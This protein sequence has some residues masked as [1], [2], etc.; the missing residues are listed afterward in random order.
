M[1]RT[2]VIADRSAFWRRWLRLALPQH[3]GLEVLVFDGVPAVLDAVRQH[4]VDLLIVELRLG[5]PDLCDG[6]AWVSALRYAVGPA[7]SRIVATISGL[8]RTGGSLARLAGADLAYCKGQDHVQLRQ[9]LAAWTAPR[10]E[11]VMPAPSRLALSHDAL[12]VF[13]PMAIDRHG[14]ARADRPSHVAFEFLE[15]LTGNLAL[16][17]RACVT[18][19]PWAAAALTEFASECRAAGALRAGACAEGMAAELAAGRDLRPEAVAA[20]FRLLV[21]TSSAM[22]HW[23]LGLENARS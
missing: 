3:P 23:L 11:P 21:E 9:H 5:E 17:R 19:D 10:V 15:M 12:P 14:R 7:P 18:Q 4:P 1:V 13:E 2:I 16:L 8:D 22:G 20:Y 6:F